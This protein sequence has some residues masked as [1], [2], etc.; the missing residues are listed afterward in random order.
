VVLNIYQ[1]NIFKKK[2]RCTA[3]RCFIFFLAAKM[4]LR[5]FIFF[6][7]AKIAL[8]SFIFFLAAKIALH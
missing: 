1:W 2:L 7:A 8:R 5:S 4:A 6:L 3:L